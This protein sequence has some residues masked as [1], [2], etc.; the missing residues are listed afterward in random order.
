MPKK[1]KIELPKYEDW[2]APWEV[3]AEGND[4]PVEDQ[5]FDAAKARKLIF[6]RTVDKLRVQNSLVETTERAE[7]LESQIA[8]AANPEELTKVQEQLAQATKERD[9]AKTGTAAETLRLRIALRKGLDEDW[10]DRLRG[11]TEEELEA[12]ADKLLKSFGGNGTPA[13]DDGHGNPNPRSTPRRSVT[14]GD[15]VTGDDPGKKEPTEAE[16]M[17]IYNSRK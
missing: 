3:D 13:G 8:G 1:T 4:I 14:P 15:P 16:V 17:A 5:Q 2:K 11:G 6:D 7:E 9:E 10:A 12:D